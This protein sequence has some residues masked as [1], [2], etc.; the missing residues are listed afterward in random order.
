MI[1]N[2]VYLAN[3]NDLKSRRLAQFHRNNTYENKSRIPHVYC[4]GDS[5]YINVEQKLNPLQGPFIIN[6]VHTNGTVTIRRSPTI[7]ERINIR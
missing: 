1:L 4:I 5:V 3:G 6:E 7:C 2:A